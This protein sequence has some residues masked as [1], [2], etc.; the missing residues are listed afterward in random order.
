[1]DCAFIAARET[2]VKYR[3]DS[4][5]CVMWGGGTDS[6][7]EGECGIVNPLGSTELGS[8]PQTA[9]YWLRVLGQVTLSKT[10]FPPVKVSSDLREVMQIK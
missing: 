4:C 1:M 10:K 5:M 9:T 3:R 7:A 8:N 2:K 6:A